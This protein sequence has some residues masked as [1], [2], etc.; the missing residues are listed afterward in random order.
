MSLKSQSIALEALGLGMRSQQ[1]NN[2]LAA[3]L[4]KFN[5]E[6]ELARRRH[7]FLEQAQFPEQVRQFNQN[8]DLENRKLS[9]TDLFN[10]VKAAEL[11]M[12]LLDRAIGEGDG[13]R[14]RMANYYLNAYTPYPAM[15]RGT[16][17]QYYLPI[18]PMPVAP[19]PATPARTTSGSIFQGADSVSRRAVRPTPPQ[20]TWHDR[21][22][23][24]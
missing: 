22:L 17:G 1:H 15:Q 4:Y 6:D 20:A 2:A 9:L 23:G 19:L 14:A 7:R 11:P 21:F 18:A 5:R 8:Y 16:G 24:D 12:Q 3:D 10:R 13:A